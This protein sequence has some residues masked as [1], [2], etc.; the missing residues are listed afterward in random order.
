MDFSNVVI[1][2]WAVLA[3]A[4]AS[5]VVGSIWFGPLFGKMFMD[6]MGFNKL[7]PEQQASMKKAMPMTYVWQFVM[8]LITF[9]VFAWLMKALG[10]E[11]VM[12]YLQG[13]FWVWFGFF[14]PQKIGE[15]LWGGKMKLAWLS[16]GNTAVTM[17]VAA[18]ILGYCK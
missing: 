5:M 13:A 2:Y 15:A 3:C 12:N 9:G 18:L 6:L 8:S 7:T 16:I 10:A 4:I 1:N 14:V 11:T 17:A